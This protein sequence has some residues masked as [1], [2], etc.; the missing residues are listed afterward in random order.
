MSMT[1][2]SL[3]RHATQNSTSSWTLLLLPGITM[4]R[5]VGMEEIIPRDFLMSDYAI[6][7]ATGHTEL[8]REE[9]QRRKSVYKSKKICFVKD[10]GLNA[11]TNRFIVK[12]NSLISR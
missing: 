12:L 9:R 1:P 2:N 3:P 5:M 7:K 6:T 8:M 11:V 10:D 4:E